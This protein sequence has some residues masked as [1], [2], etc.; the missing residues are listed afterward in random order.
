[1]RG[2]PD[3]A[4]SCFKASERSWGWIGGAV[5]VAERHSCR[6]RPLVT[7]HSDRAVIE[8]DRPPRSTRLAPGYE[9]L[10]GDSYALPTASRFGCAISTREAAGP[11]L[12]KDVA[13]IERPADEHGVSLGLLGE[14]A[15][16]EV[17]G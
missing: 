3:R 13:A 1:M 5:V 14:V 6:R 2:S 16:R 11:Y 10:I 8:V 7:E 12:R 15:H 9:D 4:T 17:D